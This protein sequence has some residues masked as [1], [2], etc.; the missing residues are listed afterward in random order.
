MFAPPANP[1]KTVKPK[2]NDHT[3]D[4]KLPTSGRCSEVAVCYEDSNWDSKLVVY[5]SEAVVSSGITVN[6]TKS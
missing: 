1:I 4:P 6:S 2:Y 3:R 5:S